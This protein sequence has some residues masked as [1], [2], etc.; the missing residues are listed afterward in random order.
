M[1]QQACLVTKQNSKTPTQPLSLG[2]FHFKANQWVN[3]QAQLH[4]QKLELTHCG[5][6]ATHW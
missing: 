2:A 4:Q 3:T 5:H 6:E 1:E